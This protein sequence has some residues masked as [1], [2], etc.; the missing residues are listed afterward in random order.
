MGKADGVGARSKTKSIGEGSTA[1]RENVAASSAGTTSA[2][3][4]IGR[5]GETVGARS[6]NTN[7]VAGTDGARTTA[8]V[9]SPIA[10]VGNSGRVSRALSNIRDV[11]QANI[12]DLAV[13]FGEPF[14]HLLGCHDGK[15][16][17]FG[18]G[19]TMSE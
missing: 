13:H 5:S 15:I 3:G 4:Y 1:I 18:L 10:A 16:S 2:E 12:G 17:L 9:G 11:L 19:K 8:K 7:T 6:M 14:G